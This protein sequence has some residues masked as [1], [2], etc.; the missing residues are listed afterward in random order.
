[1]TGRCGHV[2]MHN[3]CAGKDAKSG[4][5]TY[6][7]QKESEGKCACMSLDVNMKKARCGQKC[8]GANWAC[9]YHTGLCDA[10]HA[11]KTQSYLHTAHSQGVWYMKKDYTPGVHPPKHCSAHAAGCDVQLWVR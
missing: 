10:F 11:D 6:A 1:M 2:R 5:C 8:N 9:G 4:G 3:L 7:H